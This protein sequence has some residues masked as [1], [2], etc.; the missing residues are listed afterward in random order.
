MNIFGYNPFKE[1][2]G[3]GSFETIGSGLPM[4]GSTPSQIT[5]R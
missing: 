1:Y 5:S 2:R 4:V 3:R